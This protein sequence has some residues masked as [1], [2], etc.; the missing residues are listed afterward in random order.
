MI[1]EIW[2]PDPYEATSLL[3][4]T[5]MNNEMTGKWHEEVQE[6][7]ESPKEIDVTAVVASSPA[8]ARLV[9]EVRSEQVNE[10][11][12]AYNRFHNRHNRSR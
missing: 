3:R 1:A 11:H 5:A 9:E 8:L 7:L 4:W 12:L 6:D 2:A 10:P